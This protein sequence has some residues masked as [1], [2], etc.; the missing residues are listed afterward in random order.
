LNGSEGP[1]Y[2]LFH[3]YPPLLYPFFYASYVWFLFGCS[4]L[5]ANGFSKLVAKILLKQTKIWPRE[6]EV[7]TTFCFNT[8]QTI[9]IT[10][11]LYARVEL[12]LSFVHTRLIIMKLCTYFNFIFSA[13][14]ISE[15]KVQ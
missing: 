4:K 11:E 15:T 1:N 6:N 12:R 8:K 9:A 7:L 5:F 10:V 3:T 14:R 2:E 13:M